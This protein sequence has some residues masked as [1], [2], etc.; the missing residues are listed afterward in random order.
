MKR[1]ITSFLDKLPK[2]IIICTIIGLLSLS[3]FNMYTLKV[4]TESINKI[5]S[6]MNFMKL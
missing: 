4:E 5:V 3:C 1:R 6:L 2:N